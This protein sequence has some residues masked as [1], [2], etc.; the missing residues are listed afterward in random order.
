M[1]CQKTYSKPKTSE[2]KCETHKHGTG[3]T[4]TQRAVSPPPP[5]HTRLHRYLL[6]AMQMPKSR[7]HLELRKKR[8]QILLQVAD[9]LLQ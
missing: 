2:Q 4:L 7:I 9:L 3:A 1:I 5:P 6:P 8:G